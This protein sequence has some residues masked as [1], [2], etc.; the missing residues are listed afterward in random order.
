MDKFKHAAKLAL[1]RQTS[2]G[3]DRW[4]RAVG[5]VQEGTKLSRL[6]EWRR[7][8]AERRKNSSERCVQPQ[9]KP[10]PCLPHH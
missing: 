1:T 7:A 4:K 5:E 10:K 6:L 2:F 9:P 3:S 8:A